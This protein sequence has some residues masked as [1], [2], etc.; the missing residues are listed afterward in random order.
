MAGRSVPVI[1]SFL[2]HGAR[3]RSNHNCLPDLKNA[4][5]AQACSAWFDSAQNPPAGS[6]GESVLS[7]RVVRSAQASW[8][9]NVSE[10]SGRI[11]LGSGA[12]D[13]PYSLRA[14]VEEGERAANPE[15]LL[16]A[17]E[18]ACFTMSLANLLG[19]AG[20]PARDLRTTARVTLAQAGAGFD[21]TRI[22]L[23]T[24]GD[25]P[26]VDEA[27]FRDLAERAKNCTVGRALAG[28]EITLEASVASG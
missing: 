14:R 13:G 20:H 7:F 27:S 16:G 15:E 18:A 26:G 8:Q 25:V 19:E 22:E 23:R 9:G 17:A 28:T 6:M 10:G 11:S 24:V 3:L 4:S 21:I 12:F 1:G 5:L 2:S